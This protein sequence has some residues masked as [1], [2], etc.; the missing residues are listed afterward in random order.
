MTVLI[1]DSVVPKWKSGGVER[2]LKRTKKTTLFSPYRRRV[3]NLLGVPVD[4]ARRPVLVFRTGP[5]FLATIAQASPV[6]RVDWQGLYRCDRRNTHERAVIRDRPVPK[7]TGKRG[8]GVIGQSRIDEPSPAFEGFCGAELEGPYPTSEWRN[9]GR[10]AETKLAVSTTHSSRGVLFGFCFRSFR[11][12]LRPRA[13]LFVTRSSREMKFTGI[14]KKVLATLFRHAS[15]NST[16]VISVRT[17]ILTGA[18]PI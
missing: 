17:S 12:L 3:V 2:A 18:I 13:C 8:A 14:P 5:F 16:P 9:S 10:G 6:F 11:S 7:Q 4:Q 1:S 15:G